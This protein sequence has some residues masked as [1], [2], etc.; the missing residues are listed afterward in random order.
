[1]ERIKNYL[2]ILLVALGMATTFTACSDDKKSDDES[3]TDYATLIIGSW[4]DEEGTVVTFNKNGSFLWSDEEETS[5]GIW[6]LNGSTLTI[7][8]DKGTDWEENEIKTIIS[9]TK[10]TLVLRDEDGMYSLTKI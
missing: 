5:V 9:L 6:K 7:T 10:D 3:A 4:I 2:L 1:M 8:Y